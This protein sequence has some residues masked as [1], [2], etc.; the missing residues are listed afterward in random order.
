MRIERLGENNGEIELQITASAPEVDKAFEDGL[1]IF[2]E[3]YK[4]EDVAGDTALEKIR[5]A[6]D[7]DSARDAISS[8]VISFLIPFALEREEI[9]PMTSSSANAEDDPRQGEEF[10]FTVTVLPK[11]S[12][13]LSD[14][15]PIEVSIP[16][17]TEVTEQ[18]IDIQIQMLAREYAIVKVDPETG[19]ETIEVPEVTDEW[20]QKNL[21]D[22]GA[23]TL[24]DL[25]Q[26][27][28]ETSERVKD[29]QFEASKIAAIL[30][31][32]EKRFDG[33][34]SDKMIDALVD[35][36]YEALKV[37]IAQEGMTMM[38]FMLQQKT[39]EMQI[40]ASLAEQARRQLIHGFILDAVYR[41]E[42]LSL[43]MSDLLT[44]LRNMAPGNEEDAFD[45][46]Q[47]TGRVFLLKEGASRMKAANWLV[48]HS[49]I[50][51]L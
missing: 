31:Q 48:D 22:S 18:D 43:E 15:S 26:Q 28:R 51:I 19:E 45:L 16:G 25:R 37:E 2:V 38:D 35:D 39:D 29:E 5:T 10:T 40:K 6:L 41:H 13:E 14:Y 34:V 50:T 24:E 36:M 30:D 47:R 11:P 42:G 21:T 7:P 8:A 1:D 12:F 33:D 4:L 44:T 17:K 20:I 32:Y 3:Q 46:M 49:K 9:I 27:F 23:A